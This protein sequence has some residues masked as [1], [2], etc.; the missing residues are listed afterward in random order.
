MTRRSR[1]MICRK[2]CGLRLKSERKRIGGRRSRK[3]RAIIFA[4]FWRRP[5]ETRP[6]RRGYSASVARIFTRGWRGK[7][8]R[9]EVRD[10]KSKVRGQRSEVKDQRLRQLTTQSEWRARL[11]T[12]NASSEV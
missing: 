3:S 1:L 11:T 12:R 7:K 2:A 9:S 5:R 8:Q 4:R 6:K 10:Q